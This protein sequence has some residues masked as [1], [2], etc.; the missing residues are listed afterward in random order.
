[1]S[2][3]VLVLFEETKTNGYV[4]RWSFE[5]E[6]PSTTS[7]PTEIRLKKDERFAISIG[8]I[9]RE[10]YGPATY[11]QVHDMMNKTFIDYE[12]LEKLERI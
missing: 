2:Y 12:R 11:Q 1:M 5:V 3:P 8:Q 9:G 10:I 6:F 4:N 7:R